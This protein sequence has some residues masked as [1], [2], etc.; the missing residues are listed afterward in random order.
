MAIEAFST[1]S[2]ANGNL[3]S[4]RALACNIRRPRRMA[5]NVRARLKDAE[6][7][8][9]APETAREGACA[10]QTADCAL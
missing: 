7:S 1:A 4:A 9:G 6:V 8:G 2:F 5:T 3:G 10:P